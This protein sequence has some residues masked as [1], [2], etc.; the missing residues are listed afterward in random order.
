M[1][2]REGGR[3]EHG[4]PVEVHV[5]AILVRRVDVVAGERERENQRGREGG[6]RERGGEREGERER[7]SRRGEEGVWG[8]PM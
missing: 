7:V 6:E 4:T 8:Y 5:L 2:E 1:R 3:P